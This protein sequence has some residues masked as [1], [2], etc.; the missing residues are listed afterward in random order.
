VVDNDESIRAVVAEA[1]RDEGY[2]VA[3]AADGGAALALLAAWPP[4]RI[5][6]DLL[7]PGMDGWAFMEAYQQLA[8]PYAPVIL[9]TAA[10]LTADGTIAGR[11]LPTAAGVLAKPFDLDGL[12]AAVQAAPPAEVHRVSPTAQYSPAGPAPRRAAGARLG[13]R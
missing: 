7:M 5:L 13:T 8:P 2:Q 3:Q 11:P 6:L 1:L 12:L 10:A 9:L 4:D